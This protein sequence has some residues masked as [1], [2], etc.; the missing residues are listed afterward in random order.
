MYA[1]I[2]V[3]CAIS[4][5]LFWTAKT[6]Y[7]RLVIDTKAFHIWDFSVDSM[8][9]TGLNSLVWLTFYFAFS[10]FEWSEFLS[11]QCG[12]FFGT[13]GMLCC[14]NAL[15]TGPGGPIN[16]IMTTEVIYTTLILAV[17]FE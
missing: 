12:A 5:P 1:V 15:E 7:T 8:L 16:A 10:G 14:M 13:I 9:G 11:A 2:A 17:W 3:I 4:A 6:Y